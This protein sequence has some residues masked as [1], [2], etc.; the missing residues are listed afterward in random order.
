MA[1]AYSNIILKRLCN[2]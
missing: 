2:S 1:I